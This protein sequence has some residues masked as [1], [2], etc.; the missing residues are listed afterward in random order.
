[1]I[2]LTNDSEKKKHYIIDI[3]KDGDQLI[4]VYAD[5][6]ISSI[7][8]SEHNLNVARYKMIEQVKDNIYEFCDYVAKKYITICIKNVVSVISSLIGLFFLYNIDI[9]IVIKIIISI[10]MVAGEISYILFN[11]KK[12]DILDKKLRE[13]E[14]TDFYINHLDELKEYDRDSGNDKFVLDIEDISK[15]NISKDLLEE[16]LE[17]VKNFKEEGISIS[18]MKLVYK[19]ESKSEC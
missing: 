19:L 13:A 6:S 5:K 14:A 11:K 1:M 12:I 15:Y 8:Y 7:Y 4:I 16:L 10:L 17:K 3:K 9:S 2:L 18:E